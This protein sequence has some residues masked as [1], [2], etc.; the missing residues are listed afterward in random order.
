MSKAFTEEEIRELK[1]NPNTFKVTE[2]HLSLT[3]AAKEEV[4]ALIHEG[5]SAC[6]IAR[7]LGYDPKVLGKSRCDGIRYCVLKDAEAGR[8][9]REGYPER[10]PKRMSVEEMEEL[11]LDQESVQ[12]MRN[13]LV[14]LR[15]EV[16]FLKKISQLAKS[17]KRGD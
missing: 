6:E 4:L 3:K 14:Y 8:E 10:R 15:Q 2:A 13:E 12:R 9:Q 7:R 1:K 16:D 11:P 5:V 17:G